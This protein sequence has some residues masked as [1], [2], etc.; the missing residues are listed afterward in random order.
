MAQELFVKAS[1][2]GCQLSMEHPVKNTIPTTDIPDI[3]LKFGSAMIP[4]LGHGP[5][6][7]LVTI[8]L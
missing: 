4:A 7:H 3:L 6:N 8:F 2:V 5:D 1:M